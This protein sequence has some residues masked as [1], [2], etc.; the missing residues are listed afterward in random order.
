MPVHPPTPPPA[1]ESPVET[2]TAAPDYTVPGFIKRN[3]VWLALS[4]MFGG[5]GTNLTFS[6]GPLMVVQLLGSPTFAG[7]SVALHSLSRFVA[8]YPF[9]RV[10]DRYGRIPGVLSGLVVALVGTIAIGLAMSAREFWPLV[11]GML[12]FGIGSSGIQQLRLAAAE[13]YPPHRRATVVGMVL[14]GA[15]VGV[16]VSPMLVGAGETLAPRLGIERLAIPWLLLPVL[17]VPAI[18]LIA[19]VRPDPREI[20][21]NLGRYY[22]GYT[23][24]VLSRLDA[25]PQSFGLGDF[26]AN[27]RRQLGG[28]AMFSAQ[29]SMQ[30]AMV[31]APL[32]M[33]QRGVSLPGIAFAMAVHSAGMFA[34]SIPVG[35]LADRVGRLPVLVA[36]AIV[37]AIGGGVAAF[38]SDPAL[39]TLGIFLVGLGWCGV[40]VASTA[41]VVDS[42]PTAVR[43]RAVG[44]LDTIAAVAGA[45]FS[46]GAGPLA[47]SAGLGST[48][49]LAMALMVPP[50]VL[51]TWRWFAAG[52]GILAGSQRDAL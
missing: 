25:S 32:V 28:I 31:T 8:A 49:I 46:L 12:V 50:S 19:R 22:P 6:L 30:I 40:N 35:R 16:V 24:P 23:P 14:S 10:T 20:A 41:I 27:P 48:G 42:T 7:V 21:A 52:P 39:L 2:V 1:A 47:A 33:I 11:L 3:T 37:E 36:G 5:A 51:V 15:L 43:G 34:P 38:T 9:G 44:V 17:I 45:A 29:G 18:V 13:M 26:F 4:Q